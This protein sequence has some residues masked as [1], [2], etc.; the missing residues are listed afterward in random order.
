MTA[1]QKLKSHTAQSVTQRIK[2]QYQQEVWY[3]ANDVII[4]IR[5]NKLITLENWDINL[6]S[7]HML[8]TGFFFLNLLMSYS[9]FLLSRTSWSTVTFYLKEK[10]N[11]WKDP[12]T[13]INVWM[14]HPHIA[15]LYYKRISLC[16]VWPVLEYVYWTTSNESFEGGKNRR[17]WTANWRRWPFEKTVIVTEETGF[18]IYK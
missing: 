12:W 13:L 17:C 3:V 11:G 4:V 14:S 16:I 6:R 8:R 7:D 2:E 18:Y 10:M 9:V 1:L 5:F 15:L